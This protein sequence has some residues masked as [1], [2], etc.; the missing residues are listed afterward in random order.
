[1][2]TQVLFLCVYLLYGTSHDISVDASEGEEY[3]VQRFLT[4]RS[5]WLMSR[6]ETAGV[7]FEAEIGKFALPESDSTVR[8]VLMLRQFDNISKSLNLL[9]YTS[10]AWI[11]I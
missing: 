6:Y 10:I 7:N 1:M 9:I 4:E 8:S 2:Q 11:A 5:Q 3:A